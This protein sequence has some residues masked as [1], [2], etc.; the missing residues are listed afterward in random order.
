MRETTCDAEG[1]FRFENLPSLP[2][3][4]LTE[5]EWR[6]ANVR[7]G[8]TLRHDVSPSAGI[9]QEVIMSDRSVIGR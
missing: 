7:Q 2:W 3:I 6:V 1:K 9:V 5:V 4:I 8:G